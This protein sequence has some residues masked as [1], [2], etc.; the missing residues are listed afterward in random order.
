MEAV[1]CRST[2]CIPLFK[3]ATRAGCSCYDIRR[4]APCEARST[5]ADSFLGVG[6]GG[7]GVSPGTRPVVMSMLSHHDARALCRW[8]R[9]A[10]TAPCPADSADNVTPA[11]REDARTTVTRR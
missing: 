9:I 1:E 8:S 6:G 11:G 3:Q 2:L 7:G 10:Q 4:Y 5:N